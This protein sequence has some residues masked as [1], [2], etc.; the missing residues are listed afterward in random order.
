MSRISFLLP[1]LLALAS[2]CSD[3][4]DGD[5]SASAD[6][7][8]SLGE[9]D[10][11]FRQMMLRYTPPGSGETREISM[12]MWYPAAP[13]SGAEPAVY[14]VAGV[15]SV[16]TDVALDAPPLAEGSDFPLVIYSHGSGGQ[17]LLGY[18][19]GELMASHG[20]ILASA[21]HAGNTA[22]DDLGGTSTPGARNQLN[23]PSDITAVIDWLESGLTDDDLA[24]AADTSRVFVIGHSAGAYTAFA[25]A[26]ATPDYD[27]LV[28]GC[29]DESP[30]ESCLVYAEPEV[31]AAFRA[32]LG[33]P[34]VVA[35]ATQAPGVPRGA[36]LAALEVPTML[37]SGL[38]DRTTPH[39]TQAAPAWEALDNPDDIWVDMPRGAHFTFITICH[40]LT[41]ALINV[42]QSDAF[43]DGCDFDLSP[44][45]DDVVPIL[46]AYT[47][48]FGRI[49]VLGETEWQAVLAGPTLGDFDE[50]F[51]ITSR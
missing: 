44:R 20:W 6:E 42:I 45:T 31:E 37:M 15:V 49:H 10:V 4:A 35:V 40:D 47:L 30:S 36:D 18:P 32:G 34:R 7:L 25:A 12:R 38:L 17:A 2:G 50:E 21:N 5:E 28:E 43:D 14:A 41:A 13:D 51:E 46:A 9:F 22:L 24:G 39:A 27:A 16:P 33:D 8:L 26:G 1:L 11:G 3:G 23:R 29:D 48:G 19:Y